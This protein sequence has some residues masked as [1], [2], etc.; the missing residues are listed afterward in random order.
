[1][2]KAV[3]FSLAL[4]PRDETVPAYLW[5]YNALRDA[6]LSGRLA[7][8]SALPA[9]RELAREY[10][11]A[12]GTAIAA[13]DLLKAEG[14]AD[15][16]YGSGTYVS[17]TLPDDLL[18]VRA[19]LRK[20]PAS[21]AYSNIRPSA[22]AKRVEAFSVLEQRPTHAFRINVPA[23]DEFPT[24]LWAQIS[25]RVL[26]RASTSLLL[27]CD[28]LGYPPLQRAICGYLNA[29]RG[30]KCAPEQIAIV[31]G[32]QEAVDV[33]SRLVID[34]GDRVGLEDPGYAGAV[35]ALKMAGAKVRSIPV[36]DE[37]LCVDDARLRGCRL[38]Y[39]TPA[40][41][42]PLGVTMSLP[43]RL[44]LLEWAATSNAIVFEDDYDSEYRYEGRPIP[45]LQGLDRAG[46]VF[47][48]GTFSK[49]L[50]PSLRL[51]YL[52][53]PP[54]FVDRVDALRSITSRHAP[55]LEQAAL[56]DFITEG[57]FGRH[58]RRMREIYAE[59]LSV[60]REES[61]A[62]LHGLLDVSPVAAGLQTVG[63]L[64]D[65]IDDV[66]AARAAAQR[67]VEIIPLSSHCR[68]L[69]VA[70]G[71]QLGFAPFDA[72]EIRRGVKDLTSALE[73]LPAD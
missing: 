7:P 22:L 20:K 10:G 42:Y 70:S 31:T 8:G 37:G 69:R 33:V 1:M 30:V 54:N 50:F 49:V 53:I 2:K 4:P 64:R 71:V 25:S 23:L 65:G 72:K 68:E 47:F 28:P 63:R 66:A 18:S 41:Q 57:H 6:I 61:A 40:H 73:R 12:R 43:R 11:V 48:A 51:G 21:A 36:D 27:G 56:C 14:Y 32:V 29:S 13:F 62:H 16:R 67:N 38:V 9:T 46:V 52:V 3:R 45:A 59:R 39:V 19:G 26:R 5:L 58:L 34:P 17:A 44:K 24:T 60:L 15:G 35:S 55:V